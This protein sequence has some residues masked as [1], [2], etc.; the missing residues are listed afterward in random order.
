MLARTICTAIIASAFAAGVSAN[1][2][3]QIFPARPVRILAPY[4]PGSGPDTMARLITGRLS[5]VCCAVPMSWNESSPTTMN[6][7][8][9]GRH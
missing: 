7:S 4:S 1:L 8:T 2:K 6:R 9:G 3:A 5:I